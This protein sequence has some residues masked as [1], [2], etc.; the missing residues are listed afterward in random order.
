MARLSTGTRFGRWTVVGHAPA[1]QV[2]GENYRRACV[3][4]ECV[5]GVRQRALE[6]DLK[7]GRSSGCRS[8]RCRARWEAMRY[9]GTMLE[10]SK[11]DFVGDG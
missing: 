8:S 9:I 4:V 11:V 2:G 10:E 5:C 7:R 3:Y 1:K 6:G